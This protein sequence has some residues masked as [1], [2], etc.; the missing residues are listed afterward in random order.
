MLHLD[1]AHP[2]CLARL[3]GPLDALR[4]HGREPLRRDA[5]G[6]SQVEFDSAP[7]A[8]DAA[9]TLADDGGTHRVRVVLG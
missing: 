6:V 4:D 1:S 5:W 3:R 8:D 2:A 7:L 9:I